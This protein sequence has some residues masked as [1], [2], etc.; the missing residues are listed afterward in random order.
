[1][2]SYYIQGYVP[3]SLSTRDHSIMH[4]ESRAMIDDHEDMRVLEM[5]PIIAPMIAGSC[6]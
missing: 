1:M 5:G 3:H 4:R 6:A 2:L